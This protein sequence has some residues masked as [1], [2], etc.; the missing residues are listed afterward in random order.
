MSLARQWLSKDDREF[1]AA[2]HKKGIL[3]LHNVITRF[4]E[5]KTEH[6]VCRGEELNDIQET[7]AL[8]IPALKESIKYTPRRAW[9]EYRAAREAVKGKS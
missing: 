9:G 1:A 3:S 2:V 5:G 8:F 7:L 4:T 6:Y